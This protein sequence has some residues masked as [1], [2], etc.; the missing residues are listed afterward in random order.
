MKI[1]IFDVEHGQCA[2]IHC[3]TSGKKLMID[4]GHKTGS[5]WPSVHFSGQQ[6]EVLI[7]SNYDEDHTS[8]VASVLQYCSV[9]AIRRNMSVN[10]ARLRQMKAQ[11]G[12]GLGIQHVHD[13]IQWTETQPGGAPAQVDLGHVTTRSYYNNYGEGVGQFT[14]ANNLSVVTFVTYSNFTI[15]FPGDLEAVGWRQLLL[16]P[17]FQ[18][19]LR[20]I[21][22]LVA[23]HHGRESGCC[24]EI[25]NYCA[26]KAVI[27]SDAGLQHASQETR[28]WYANRVPGY[29][30]TDGTIRKVL[31]TCYD[32]TITINVSTNGM[33]FVTTERQRNALTPT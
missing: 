11:G 16:N 29:Q 6:I 19:D 2:M 3:P 27:I 21:T 9:N 20:R 10:S 22:V 31:T 32:G 18:A 17:A 5:W 24:T 23:S 26:P 15:L 30:E 33:G 4:A 8:D 12:M 14:D 7:I 13:W 28:G 1:E 25:F